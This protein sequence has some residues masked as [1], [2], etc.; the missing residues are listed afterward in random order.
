M[1]I[2]GNRPFLLSINPRQRFSRP[3]EFGTMAI[4]LSRLGGEYIGIAYNPLG[5]AVFGDFAFGDYLQL[6]GIYQRQYSLTSKY[7]VRK[8]LYVSQNPRTIPQQANRGKFQD[9]VSAYQALTSE[10]KKVYH[11][12]AVGKQMSGYNLFLREYMLS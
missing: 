9:A 5:R 10:Q 7:I 11:T 2:L 12:R 8:D 6:T 3:A 1:I 4:G